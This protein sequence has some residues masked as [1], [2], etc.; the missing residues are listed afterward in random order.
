[1]MVLL[2]GEERKQSEELGEV[3]SGIAELFTW[4]NLI[5]GRVSGGN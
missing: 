5:G 3:S 4:L 1:M 2:K